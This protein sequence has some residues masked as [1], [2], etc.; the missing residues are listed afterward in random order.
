MNAFEDTLHR[1]IARYQGRAV[2]CRTSSCLSSDPAVSIGI[3]SIKIVT[4]EQIQALAFAM[5]GDDPQIVVRLDPI[6][7]DVNDLLPFAEFLNRAVTMAMQ[8]NVDV[9]V[10]IPHE[11]TLE[12]LDVLG[13]RYW[14]NQSAPPEIQRMG[15]ICRIIAHEAKI[16]GQQLVAIATALLQEHVVTGLAP[17]EEGH[18]NA[19]LAWLDPAV[20]DPVT[21]ARERIRVPA[22]GVLPN[23]PDH[24]LDDRVD[25]LRKEAKA[26]SGV[27][28]GVLQSEI[29]GIL[30]ASVLREWAMLLEARRAFLGL[31]LPA[32]GL[33]QLVKDSNVRVRNDLEN[34]FYPAR[35]PHLLAGQL[36][37]MEAG[38]EKSEVAILEN[39]GLMRDQAARAGGVVRG[40]VA[41][42]RQPRSGFKP[43]DI[44]VD[45][46]QRVIRFRLDDKIKIVGTNVAG[47]VRAL[48]TAPSGGTTVSIEITSGVRTRHVL[49]VGAAIELIREPYGFVNFR[50]LNEARAQGHWTFY[51]TTAPALPARQSSGRSAL[52]IARVARRP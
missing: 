25:R 2:P 6:G 38:L 20:S 46:A 49:A 26:A 17:L 23:T 19:I 29:A 11:A 39:D 13:H 45:S 42:V 41:A 16:P 30:R 32:N 21:E 14:R 4:E 18:L 28:K 27:R 1:I 52:A 12:A 31:G 24:P 9:R 10:W 35:A 51:G 47:V 44:D 48:A 5:L 34:G 7:R 8:Q 36:S 50:A 15:E 22:S 40:V 43:C 3:A 37:V 33:D